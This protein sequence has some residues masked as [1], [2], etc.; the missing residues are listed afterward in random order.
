MKS[1]CV[2]ADF[3]RQKRKKKS[4]KVKPLRARQ[5]AALTVSL[6]TRFGCLSGSSL[7]RFEDIYRS[8]EALCHPKPDFSAICLNRSLAMQ[9]RHRYPQILPRTDDYAVKLLQRLDSRVLGLNPRQGGLMARDHRLQ[10][11]QPGPRASHHG[12]G[13]DEITL[14]PANHRLCHSDNAG[15][16]PGKLFDCCQRL[17]GEAAGFILIPARKVVG[18]E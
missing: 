6:K 18:D 8:A 2:D 9:L 5:E 10:R 12:L 14:A 7:R 13:S 4:A 3:D 11:S 15:C 1:S 16:L 17:T